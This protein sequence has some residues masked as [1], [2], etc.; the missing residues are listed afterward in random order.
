MTD[1][2]F[3][4]DASLPPEDGPGMEEDE[5]DALNDETFGADTEWREDEWEKSHEQLAVET[6]TARIKQTR[7]HHPVEDDDED[8]LVSGSAAA[9]LEARLTEIILDEV[10]SPVKQKPM[11]S[12][13][14]GFW[15]PIPSLQQRAPPKPG[16][17][18][19]NTQHP[20][21]PVF[22]QLAAL[23]HGQPP[24]QQV[25]K[26]PNM[27]M[28][29]TVEDLERDLRAKSQAQVQ[30]AQAQPE[31]SNF[32]SPVREGSK[33]GGPVDSNQLLEM[34][35]AMGSMPEHRP[36]GHPPSSQPDIVLRLA[37]NQGKPFM[38]QPPPP[39]H[40]GGIMMPPGPMRHPPP[41]GMHRMP[42]NMFPPNFHHMRMRGEM[43]FPWMNQPMPV[44]MMH[45]QMHPPGMHHPHPAQ[46]MNQQHQMML[47]HQQQQQQQQ[48]QHQMQ[49]Q[50]LRQNGS[51]DPYAGLMTQKDK[52]WLIN[53]QILQ[54]NTQKP[55]VDDFYYTAFQYKLQRA[56][57]LAGERGVRVQKREQRT[58]EPRT[59]T[60][61]QF[62][63]S[64][65]KLQV[66]SVTAPRKIIDMEIMNAEGQDAQT[67]ARDTR[68]V[69]QALLELERLYIL[70]LQLEDLEHPLLEAKQSV[71]ESKEEIVWKVLN[72][73]IPAPNAEDKL[74][75]LLSVRK[76]KILLQRLF[77]HLTYSQQTPIWRSLLQNFW[78]ISRKDAQEQVLC[79]LFPAF[80]DW[81]A[82]AVLPNIVEVISA[83]LPQIS[84]RNSSPS[85]ITTRSPLPAALSN[86]FGVSI[87]TSIINRAGELDDNSCPPKTHPDWQAWSTFVST[88]SEVS[89]E[90]SIEPTTP[91]DPLAKPNSLTRFVDNKQSQTLQ[92]LLQID[93][94]HAE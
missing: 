89:C 4:F 84:E 66:V 86:K 1:S 68:K 88:I 43:P 22:N 29:R 91:L 11:L 32:G 47:H 48:Q 49:Q 23:G 79:E 38:H 30:R 16:G 10:E 18:F 8:G 6:E 85:N 92:R 54:L 77:P 34:L 72:T 20:S 62:E 35:R 5:Y 81:S 17:S 24:P 69:K 50:Q 39:P 60:P 26:P 12:I 63:G 65:G 53:I 59:Y 45:N 56:R 15:P 37:Q 9:Q 71:P 78:S 25:P 82:Q 83:M 33:P 7:A 93:N 31:G 55:Y 46:M 90:L 3:D 61:A 21:M 40:N 52:Q 27:V 64:L 70:V 44:P 73:I 2:F 58:L 67:P 41:P 13:P 75:L 28:V 14:P 76:G 19:E 36:Q 57:E 80:R 87:I 51:H 42:P 74:P 94:K